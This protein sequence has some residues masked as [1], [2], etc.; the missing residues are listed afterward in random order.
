MQSKSKCDLIVDDILSKIVNRVYSAGDRLP[1]ESELCDL[2]EV[3]RVTI[4]ESLKK[5][6]IMDLIS[7]EQGRGTFV[8]EIGLGNFMQPMFNLINFGDFDINTIYDARLF[9]ETGTCR[10][11]A[12]NRT[13]EDMKVLEI[14]V[15][16]MKELIGNGDEQSMFAMQEI[17]TQFHVQVARTSRNE[18]LKAAVINLEKISSACAERINKSHA[19]MRDVSGDHEKILEAIRNQDPDEAERA[20]VE[21]TLKSKEFLA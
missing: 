14:L 4:R 7:I 20:I 1:T 3:S 10:L 19:V 13:Q 17:D 6:E 12:L 2:Y 18:I 8:K 9:I 5:L 21:H 15:Q 11:A 16:K